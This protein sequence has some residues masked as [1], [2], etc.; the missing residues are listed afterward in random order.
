MTGLA[1]VGNVLNHINK[2]VLSS[3]TVR[4]VWHRL[5]SSTTGGVAINA[6]CVHNRKAFCVTGLEDGFLSCSHSISPVEASTCTV[7]VVV[8]HVSM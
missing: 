1:Y 7:H 8:I 6:L 3:I 2:N 5:P 4:R